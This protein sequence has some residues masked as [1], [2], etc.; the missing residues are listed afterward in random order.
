MANERTRDTLASPSDCSQLEQYLIVPIK[1]TEVSQV[2]WQLSISP[3]NSCPNWLLASMELPSL[4]AKASSA[5]QEFIVVT[6]TS[7]LSAVSTLCVP[8]P[9]CCGPFVLHQLHSL[10]G[11]SRNATLQ[12]ETNVQLGHALPPSASEK[13]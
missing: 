9:S 6:L 7:E 1:L 4:T 12:F 8:S 11:A 13:K 10:E 3:P 5:K 2:C